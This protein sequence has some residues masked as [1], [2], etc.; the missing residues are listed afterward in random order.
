MT[1]FDL[2]NNYTINLEALLRKNRSH[3]ASSSAT[4]PID[5]LVTTAPSA[6]PIMAKTLRDYSVPTVANVPLGQ[7]STLAMK[8]LSSALAS[9]MVQANQFSS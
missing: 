2:P 9:S 1:N 5:K 4:P 3:V 6:T 7:L 8:T